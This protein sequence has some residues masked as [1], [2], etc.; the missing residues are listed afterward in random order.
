MH[1]AVYQKN[2]NLCNNT[3]KETEDLT[4]TLQDA[5]YRNNDQLM[6]NSPSLTWQFACVDQ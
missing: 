2:V 1:N 4:Y 6:V 3:H 5:R